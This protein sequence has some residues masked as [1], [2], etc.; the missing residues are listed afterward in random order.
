MRILV[1][2]CIS[3]F[4]I[5]PSYGA[6]FTIEMLNKKGKE[7]MIFS[8]K[9]IRINSGDMIFWKAK[10]K[11]HNVE[12]ITKNG[13]PDGVGKF[14]SKLSKDTQY[15]FMVPGIYAYWCTPHKSM[16][17]IGFI[18]VDSNL[19]NLENIKKVKFFGK[20]KKLAKKLL[21]ELN[22]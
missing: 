17:M 4:C 20:S 9:I 18:I 22:N 8:E 10:S 11:G 5:T 12:F 14:K 2:L 15:K 1:L 7:K 16:G 13:I 19:D 21:K 6:D 3:F